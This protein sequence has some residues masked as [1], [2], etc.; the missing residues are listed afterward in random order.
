MESNKVSIFLHILFICL[1]S[2]STAAKQPQLDKA[3]KPL[4]VVNYLQPGISIS[5]IL[6]LKAL[7][8]SVMKVTEHEYGPY[9][10]NVI[11]TNLVPMRKRQEMLKGDKI[12]LIW[13]TEDSNSI[14]DLIRVPFHTMKGVLGYRVMIIKGD[15]QKEF[16][17]ITNLAQLQAMRPGQV[18]FWTDTYIYRKNNFE[19]VTAP[20]MSLLFPMLDNNRFDFFPLG[21]SEVNQEHLLV[22]QKY[23]SLA[24]ETDLMIKYSLPIYFMV[25]PTV[26]L[27]AERLGNGFLAIEKNGEFDKLFNQYIQ[28]E[29]DSLNIENRTVI[30]LENL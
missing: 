14:K 1:A 5:R 29:M 22:R 3:N 7:L 20:K 6:Y 8:D 18:E 27:L 21:A 11:D 25:S 4:Q 15:R 10:I 30:Q 24:I 28:P 12:N 9:K 23:P 16:S 26:P 13:T 17:K 2:F 19:V